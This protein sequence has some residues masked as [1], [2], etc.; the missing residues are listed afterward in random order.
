MYILTEGNRGLI[1]KLLPFAITL[2]FTITI[3]L[4]L[5]TIESPIGIVRTEVVSVWI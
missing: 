3:F 5:S 1:R 4:I 2:I